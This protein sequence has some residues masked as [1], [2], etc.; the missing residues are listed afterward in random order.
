VAGPLARLAREA[1]APAPDETARL[2]Q[3][4]AVLR[5]EYAALK[6]RL[7]RAELRGGKLAYE[8]Q[9]LAKLK[10]CA[11][12]Y[13]D[14][15]T[16][17]RQAVLDVGEG[18]GVRDEAGVLNADGVVGKLTRVDASTSALLLLSDPSCR[19]SA[20]LAR[21]GLQCSVQGDGRR[22]CL[23]E[24]LGGQDDVRVGDVVE[25][26]AGGRSFPS[27]VPVGRVIRL[28]R[29]EG[30]LQLQAE[31]EP[32]TDLSRLEGLYVWVGEPKP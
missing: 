27:G 3:E 5:L 7:D 24:H 15:A 14:P 1:T 11:L 20:R 12:L 23:L 32:A 8:H 28:A 16:W 2:R 4:L 30:G 21:T 6:E 17:F 29:L 10:P 26:G 13:R 9:R 25:T 22:A 19:F 31:V 18:D